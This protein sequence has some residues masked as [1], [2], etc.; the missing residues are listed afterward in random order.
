MSGECFGAKAIVIGRSKESSPQLILIAN[1]R[2]PV[3][4]YVLEFPAGLLDKGES[5]E[6]CALREVKVNKYSSIS[7]N[8]TFLDSWRESNFSYI[9]TYTYIGGDRVYRENS[10][11]N[12]SRRIYSIYGSMEKQ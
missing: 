7:Y 9:Y 6:A 12:K 11:R 10:E 4:N 1:Y 5:L 8:F 2:I 3:E